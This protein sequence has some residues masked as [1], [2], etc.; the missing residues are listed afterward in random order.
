MRRAGTLIGRLVS[1][2][3]TRVA[4]RPA[5]V[6]ALT[7]AVAGST[8]V[9]SASPGTF[10]GSHIGELAAV[11]CSSGTTCTA[12]GDYVPG[13]D[14]PQPAVALAYQ[15]DGRR[16]SGKPFPTV[17]GAE[18]RAVSCPSA[19]SCL[20]VGSYGNQGM[21]ERWDGTSWTSQPPPKTGSDDLLA[22]SCPSADACTVVGTSN[23]SAAAWTWNGSAWT[24]QPISIPSGPIWTA[25]PA[26]R[27]SSA[28]P[29]DS[30]PTGPV[31]RC[32]WSVG[33]VRRGLT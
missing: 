17:S 28:L 4:T 24:S 9:A 15:W 14:H 7:A 19:R 30:D 21:V 10:S 31:G 20:S 27:R 23:G 2:L 12:V 22:V 32:W 26:P 29:W 8:G 16:W 18:P 5:V 13:F 33:T 25:S 11:S 6:A 3:R 1:R